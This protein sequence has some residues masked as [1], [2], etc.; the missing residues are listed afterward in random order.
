MTLTAR[1]LFVA[2]GLLGLG[3]PF[4]LRAMEGT[5][6]K[7]PSKSRSVSNRPA[8]FREFLEQLKAEQIQA[9]SRTPS[10]DELMGAIRVFIG[11]CIRQDPE[12]TNLL[13]EWKHDPHQERGYDP[14]NNSGLDW[15][16]EACGIRSGHTVAIW[17]FL[18]TC[19]AERKKAYLEA[20]EESSTRINEWDLTWRLQAILRKDGYTVDGP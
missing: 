4:A 3:Q 1:H 10:A 19:E 2:L 11:Y 20:F 18:E 5:D 12:L 6:E 15:F 13:P 14:G 8:S 9:P 17:H 16:L 7:L